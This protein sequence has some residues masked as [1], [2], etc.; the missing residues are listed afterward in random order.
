MS[1]LIYFLFFITGLSSL[2]GCTNQITQVTNQPSITDNTTLVDKEKTALEKVVLEYCSLAKDGKVAS[3]KKLV[4]KTPKSYWEYQDRKSKERFPVNTNQEQNKE[5][6][7][8]QNNVLEQRIST[9]PFDDYNYEFLIKRLPQYFQK[10]KMSVEI[11]D[12]WVK[13]N[14]ARIRIEDVNSGVRQMDFYLLRE[15]DSQWRVFKFDIY[16]FNDETYPM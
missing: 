8:N 10:N 16:F 14:E 1:K 6:N 5:I 7:A 2:F 4:T 3:L 11:I 15:P 12:T 9:K 13:G